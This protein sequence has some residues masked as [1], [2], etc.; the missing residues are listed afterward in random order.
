M[1]GMEGVEGMEGQTLEC[2]V[3]TGGRGARGMGI[4]QPRVLHSSQVAVLGQVL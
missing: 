2:C 3:S 4:A 1:E